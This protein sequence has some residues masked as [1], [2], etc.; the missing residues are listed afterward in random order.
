MSLLHGRCVYKEDDTFAV[1][2]N[3]PLV[4]LAAEIQADRVAHFTGHG[5]A[6]GGVA[7]AGQC[8]DG[9][10][11]RGGDVLQLRW[12]LCREASGWKEERYEEQGTETSHDEDLSV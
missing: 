7:R 5:G 1:R 6:P 10:D 2:A 9:E 3:V 11:L 4:D 12:L 8:A